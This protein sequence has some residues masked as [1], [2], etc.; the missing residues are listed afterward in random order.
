MFHV[1]QEFKGNPSSLKSFEDRDDAVRFFKGVELN[2]WS[3]AATLFDG[4]TR[5]AF[6]WKAD[7]EVGI[8]WD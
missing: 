7:N 1:V 5:L 2:K 8:E 4:E 6:M 3:S